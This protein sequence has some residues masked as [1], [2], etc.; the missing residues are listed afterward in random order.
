VSTGRTTW[1]A[2][3]AAWHRRELVEEAI[4]FLQDPCI[5]ELADVYE[6]VRALAETD[7]AF[8]S[9]EAVVMEANAKR[10]E[11]GGFE[12]RVGMFVQTTAPARHEGRHAA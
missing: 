1:W 6:V 10:A 7:P 8:V 12:Q 4:E 2:K 3:D 9:M 5:G 11:R